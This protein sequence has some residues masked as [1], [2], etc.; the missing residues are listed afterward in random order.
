MP[1]MKTNRAAAKRFR[2]TKRGAIM[3]HQMGA[4]HLKTAKS[5]KRVRKLRKATTLSEREKARVKRMLP[6]S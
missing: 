6:Y 4:R 2:R 1:K 3:R 5:P